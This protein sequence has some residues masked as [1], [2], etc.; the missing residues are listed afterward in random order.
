MVKQQVE[1][2]P[3]ELLYNATGQEDRSGD[4]GRLGEG[5]SAGANVRRGINNC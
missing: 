2:L 4:L 5:R 3:R 1:T